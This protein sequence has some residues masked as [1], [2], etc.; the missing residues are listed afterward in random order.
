MDRTAYANRA[1]AFLDRHAGPGA[2]VLPNVWSPGT[3]KVVAAAGF[4]VLATTSAGI[5]FSLGLPDDGSIGRER[6]LA[7][8]A[9]IAEAVDVPVSADV[10]SGYGPEAEDVARTV[11]GV[12]AVGAVGANVEDAVAGSLLEVSRAVERVE[13]A[14]QAA[15]QSGL[16]FTLNA[17]VDSYLVGHPDPF[18]DAVTRAERYRAAGAD[19]VFIPGVSD[20]RTIGRLVAGIGAPLN[21]VAGLSGEPLDLATYERLGVRR[22]SVGGSL[23]R[24]T[25]GLVRRAA[26]DMLEHGRFDFGAGAIPHA[27]INRIFAI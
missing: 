19:C 6:M 12:I 3:A 4:D 5:A 15:D 2:F 17:R 20:E 11:T 10:E 8:I 7:E 27:E 25:L 23:A 26:A 9:A 21:V 1:R 18:A 13:A 24:A 16:P 14:R 22:I